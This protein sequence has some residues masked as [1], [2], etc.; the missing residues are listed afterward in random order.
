MEM[1]YM[2]I[3]SYSNNIAL[4]NNTNINIGN[5]S[6]GNSFQLS[7][8]TKKKV[9]N[10]RIPFS[11]REK[12]LGHRKRRKHRSGGGG[13]VSRRTECKALTKFLTG[14]LSYNACTDDIREVLGKKKFYFA[15]H[16]I[17][18]EGFWEN[19]YFFGTHFFLR[20]GCFGVKCR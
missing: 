10:L 20:L 13:P 11:F 4:E 5:L 6:A 9:N 15:Y 8:Q 7:Y 19:L 2:Y 17:H 1:K 16:I 3:T 18:L 12:H 14:L